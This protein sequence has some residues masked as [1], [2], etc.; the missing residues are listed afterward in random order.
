M[1]FVL[2]KGIDW[3]RRITVVDE[4]TGLPT[5]LT[6]KDIRLQLSRR[7]SEPVLIE[8]AVDTG[9]TL[10]AQSGATLGMAD[11]EIDAALTPTL[12]VANHVI[13]VLVDGQVVIAPTK[14]PVRDV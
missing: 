4:D 6:G 14:L 12:E 5:D 2:Y 1:A 11:I 7:T 10:L 9:I 8:L 3:R 13:A